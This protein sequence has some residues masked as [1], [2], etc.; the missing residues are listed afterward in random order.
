MS[1]RILSTTDMHA[2]KLGMTLDF[3]S[4]KPDLLID[5]GDFLIGNLFS[6]YCYQKKEIS[7][8]TR[9]ANDLGYDVMIPGN[10]DLDYGLDW[11]R[12]QVKALKAPYICANLYDACNQRIFP[13][14]H[15]HSLANGQKILV[16]GLL[17][18]AFSQ[19]T[20]ESFVCQ[21]LVKD[22]IQT[23]D[24]VLHDIESQGISTD[25]LCVAYHGGIL[26]DP[27]NGKW[28]YYPSVED[29]AYDLM[30]RFPQINSLICGHQ[31]FVNAA[32]HPNGV[33][34]VQPGSHGRYIGLQEFDHGQVQKNQVLSSNEAIP[35]YCQREYLE[36]ILT[37]YQD[38]LKTTINLEAF[39]QY[40]RETYDADRC[41]LDLGKDLSLASIQQK[42]IPPFPVSSY[43]I[44]GERLIE[45]YYAYQKKH[46]H[47]YLSPSLDDLR[48]D[49]TYKVIASPGI[50]PPERLREDHLAP[51][52]EDY[53]FTQIK[54]DWLS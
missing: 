42:L 48:K 21:S 16:I 45:C 23:L 2:S 3:T 33:A 26:Q 39:A 36:D 30:N 17:T 44:E 11:L 6:L 32:C 5:N 34:M 20:K 43:L 29:Q 40:L 13:A 4:L 46:P 15:I 14:Y 19:L 41:C 24:Q 52:L 7:P 50:L 18:G 8:L 51:V 37:D 28:L 54:P 12:S 53:L 35:N 10:H 25:L 49:Q 47:I 38:W 9:L 27:V 31:H 22:P 1:I